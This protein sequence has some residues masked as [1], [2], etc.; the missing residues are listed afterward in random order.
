MC[1]AVQGCSQ[2]A[3]ETFILYSVDVRSWPSE[4]GVLLLVVVVAVLPI[5]LFPRRYQL[6]LLHSVVSWI[7][8]DR[9]PNRY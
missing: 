7:S 4:E 6:I 8:R 2:A 5:A 9:P 3:G 1:R